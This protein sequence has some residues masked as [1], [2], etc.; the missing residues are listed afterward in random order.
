LSTRS[1]AASAYWRGVTP[2]A[3]LKLRCK[4]K[5]LMPARSPSAAS[6]N[7]SSACSSM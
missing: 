4:W 3:A 1:R 7:G 2:V 5:V 6:V